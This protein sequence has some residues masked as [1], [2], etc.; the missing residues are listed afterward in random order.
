MTSGR[1]SPIDPDL[2]LG[3]VAQIDASSALINLPMA[4]SGSARRVEPGR[5]L[6][7]AVGDYVCIQCDGRVL[8]GR[9]TEVR[10]PERDRAFVEPRIRARTDAPNPIGHVAFLATIELGSLRVSR[11][12][13]QYPRLGASVHLAPGYLV[14]M[15]AT[16]DEAEGSEQKLLELGHQPGAADAPIRVPPEALLDRHCA[17]V[18]ATGGGKSWTLARVVQEISR[19]GGKVLLIDAT[20]EYH[21][22]RHRTRH[23]FLGPGPDKPEGNFGLQPLNLPYWEMEDADLFA[24]FTPAGQSQGPMLREA[25]RSLRLVEALRAKGELPKSWITD[26][27]TVLKANQL[28]APF[29]NAVRDNHDVVEA[30]HGSYFRISSIVAQLQRECVWPTTQSGESTRWGGQDDR[31]IGFIVPLISR[32]EAFTKSQ[33]FRS[34]F[35]EEPAL[36]FATAVDEFV[37]SDDAVLRVSLRTL[38]A[39]R[40]FRQIAV[41]AMVR[42]LVGLARDAAFSDRPLI[43]AIDEAHNFLGEIPQLEDHGFRLDALEIAAKEG[44]K[45]GLH[46]V[47]ATQRPR[48]LTASV[49]SQMGSVLAHR[50][51]DS[52]D[53]AVLDSSATSLS[54]TAASFVPTLARGEA[55]LFG[56]DFIFPFVVRIGRPNPAPDSSGSDFT[57]A[58]R[59]PTGGDDD[60]PAVVAA[61]EPASFEPR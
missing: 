28:R 9:I 53:L 38:P 52:R 40:G 4:A 43:L 56:V 33:R 44:R 24:L 48:D 6:G 19:N 2:Y 41:N 60:S 46:L 1:S 27:G 59:V 51:T 32:I 23:Y 30:S 57:S 36:T 11:G 29:V 10:L 45:Y 49:M 58:W 22:L 7:G 14:A 26:E 39:D 42:Y 8:L 54:A 21:T 55:V 15:A 25:V 35:D 17:I 47:L 16:T 13:T 50:M 37:R 61:G 20:G 5:L 34:V 31:A 3:T 12:V 18:G